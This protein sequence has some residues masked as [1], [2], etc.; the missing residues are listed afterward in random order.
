MSQH[1]IS[2]PGEPGVQIRML[3]EALIA[4]DLQRMDYAYWVLRTGLIKR[5]QEATREINKLFQNQGNDEQQ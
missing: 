3:A 5:Q 2:I 4:A 1:P